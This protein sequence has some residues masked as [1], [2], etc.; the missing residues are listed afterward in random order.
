MSAVATSFR[1]VRG[2]RQLSENREIT[3]EQHFGRGAPWCVV[4]RQGTSASTLKF[5]HERDARQAFDSEWVK[6]LMSTATTDPVGT[7]MRAM[8]AFG[9]PIDQLKQV[10]QMRS[11][12][13]RKLAYHRVRRRRRG[14]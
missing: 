11:Q 2:R 7:Q 1:V 10:E 9:L 14:F 6:D 4:L 3:L 5:D 12:Y 8:K 13:N